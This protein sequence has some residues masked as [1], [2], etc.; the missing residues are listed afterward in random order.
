MDK[1]TF[2]SLAAMLAGLAGIATAVI[3]KDIRLLLGGMLI[4]MI[5]FSVSPQKKNKHQQS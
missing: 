2:F 4:V 1:R 5:I 3:F